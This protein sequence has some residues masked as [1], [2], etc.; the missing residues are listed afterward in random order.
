VRR[1]KHDERDEKQQH[2][3]GETRDKQRA[4]ESLMIDAHRSC[5]V[6]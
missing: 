3:I 2:L 4:E 6:V 5:L 1:L